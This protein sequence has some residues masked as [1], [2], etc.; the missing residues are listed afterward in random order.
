MNPL[1]SYRRKH[2]LLSWRYVPFH[3]FP[4]LF[5]SKRLFSL[6]VI[7]W[8]LSCLWLPADVPSS[9]GGFH[10][11]YPSTSSLDIMGQLLEL[12]FHP[13]WRYEKFS[14]PPA[15]GY[16]RNRGLN[17][18]ASFLMMP[19]LDQ[20]AKAVNLITN[21]TCWL[22]SLVESLESS[23]MLGSTSV[24]LPKL[25]GLKCRHP[26][27]RVIVQGSFRFLKFKYEA[28]NFIFYG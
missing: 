2:Q 9:K 7:F 5:Q 17:V 6:S 26:F 21:L 15:S 18:I 16:K 22:R 3:S 13:T 12:Q 1:E 24:S 23:A 11:W 27:G 20:L 19:I 14:S 4:C 8:P 25:N 10:E 28:S